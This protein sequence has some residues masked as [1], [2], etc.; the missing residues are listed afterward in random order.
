MK[1]VT[2]TFEL[3]F[4]DA[5]FYQYC[6]SETISTHNLDR[7]KSVVLKIDNLKDDEKLVTNKSE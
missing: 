1:R 4:P 2:V 7:A 5:Y 3:E 6:V